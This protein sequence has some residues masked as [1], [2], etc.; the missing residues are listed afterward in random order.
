MQESTSISTT[1][2]LQKAEDYY[3]LR[4]K[5]LELIE[6]LGSDLWTDYNIHDPGITTMEQ[7]CFALTELGYRTGLDIKDFL[8]EALSKGG[9]EQGFFSAQQILSTCPVTVNDYRKLLIDL[10]SLQNAWLI[11]KECACHTKVYGDCENSQLTYLPSSTAVVPKGYYDVIVQLE[12]VPA[13]GDLNDGKIFHRFSVF[14]VNRSFSASMELRF[15]SYNHLDRIA[16]PTQA[17]FD[18]NIPIL[19]NPGNPAVSILNSKEQVLTDANLSESL[20]DPLFAT[21]SIELQGVA[22]PFVLTQVPIT[23]FIDQAE[24]ENLTLS[25]LEDQ[26]TSLSDAGILQTYRTKLQTIESSLEATRTA[27]HKNRNLDEDFCNVQPIEVID[28][29]VCGDIVVAPDADIEQVLATLYFEV[30]QYFNPP[31]RFY[32][33]NELLEKEIPTE[34]IF[35]G[36]SLQHGFILEEELEVSQLKSALYTS[37]LINRFMDIEGVLAVRNLLLTAY[38]EFGRPVLPSQA[39]VLAIPPVSQA[40]LYIQQ[41]KFLFFKNELPFLP[42]NSDEVHAIYQALKGEKEQL[43][44]ATQE[45]DLPIPTGKERDFAEYYPL[46]YSFPMNY[47]VGEFGLPSNVPVIRKAQANQ[48]KGYLLFFEQILANSFSQL[49][50]FPKLFKLDTN[51]T[52]QSYF[53]AFLDNQ[54]IDG[55]QSLYDG[56]N[57]AGDLSTLIE[58]PAQANERKNTI[59]NHMMAR[60]GEQFSDYTLLLNALDGRTKAQEE[61]IID[62]INF[63]KNYPEVSK[64]RGKA[65]NYLETEE[66]CGWQNVSGLKKRLGYLFGLDSI[67]NYFSFSIIRQ[68]ETYEGTLYFKGKQSLLYPP[69]YNKTK[70]ILMADLQA[71]RD[72]TIAYISD[73]ANFS[74]PALTAPGEWTFDFKD[75]HGNT[76]ASS[77]VF[78]SQADAQAAL[79]ELQVWVDEI[80][81]NE[82]FF[83]VEHLLLAPKIPGQSLLPVCLESD[84]QTCGEEDPYSFRLTLVMPGWYE[85]FQNLDFRRFAESTVRQETPAHLLPKVCWV[86]NDICREAGGVSILCAIRDLLLAQLTV[87][88]PTDDTVI[89]NICECGETILLA[90]NEAFRIWNSENDPADFTPANLNTILTTLFE[91]QIPNGSIDCHDDLAPAYYNLVRDL[92]VNYFSDKAYCFQFNVFRKAWCSWQEAQAQLDWSLPG[93][94]ERLEKR[95]TPSSRFSDTPAAA[96]NS[97]NCVQDY[98]YAI[99]ENIRLWLV[100]NCESIISVDDWNTLITT[101]AGESWD[102]LSSACR[103]DKDA[104]QIMEIIA[105]TQLYYRDKLELLQTHA[106]LLKI[107]KQ[108]KSIYPPATLHDCE[109]GSDENPIRLNQTIIGF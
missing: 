39:W 91:N 34:E 53:P 14:L 95:W 76:L 28:V 5:G 25:M 92:V 35:N 18:P 48:F 9:F 105:A 71:L 44:L 82:Q 73:N 21:I 107:F 58:T 13:L 79:T 43:K 93:L 47:G 3:F 86:G 16:T 38:D 27:L 19:A 1:P 23:V 29:A 89:R 60:F 46:Q 84:C 99:A 108:L 85:R 33:L 20:R 41:S 57:N 104:Q 54:V 101:W 80:I 94:V 87:L 8:A 64:S 36:P 7:F 32:S 81:A 109:D 75:A 72:R 26:L 42:A 90:Y 37:D 59:L 96:A 45:N 65:F 52:P 15:P 97:C 24:K 31:V 4:E 78:T 2:E 30:E 67:R 11:C 12:E 10:K 50:N 56:L 62:K 70:R 103:A 83:V 6:Q 100:S 40:R 66:G 68:D 61:L 77:D 98:V 55:I 88:D 69:L 106:R 102:A 74:A 63:L 49:Q 17:F 22:A 51:S